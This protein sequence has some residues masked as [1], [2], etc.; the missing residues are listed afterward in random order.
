MRIISDHTHISIL[1]NDQEEA[2]R[3][4]TEKLGLE[5]RNDLS[6][7]PG[8][9]LLTVAARGQIRPTL[10]LAKP[11]ETTYGSTHVQNM[12]S[13]V[14]QHISSIFVTEDCQQT[15]CELLARGV[16]FMCTPT[17]QIYGLEAIFS[18]PYGNTFSLLEATPAILA[19]FKEL[20]RNTAA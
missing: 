8:L 6:F 18:D 11:D 4:Y 14:G 3:F 9:R 16:T 13:H 7:A 12:L 5:K 2:L 15:Y 20:Q 1:V 17:R 19:R 10:V